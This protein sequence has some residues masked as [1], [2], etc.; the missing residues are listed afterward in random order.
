MKRV[1]TAK[2]IMGTNSTSS[3]DHANDEVTDCHD[4]PDDTR[5]GGHQQQEDLKHSL[6]RNSTPQDAL[7]AAPGVPASFAPTTGPSASSGIAVAALS[8]T[9]GQGVDPFS[10]ARSSL[11]GTFATAVGSMGMFDVAPNQANN[12]FG[13][14]FQDASDGSLFP[15]G[16]SGLS[17]LD[18][19]QMV[20]LLKVSPSGISER[21]LSSQAH[22]PQQLQRQHLDS[23]VPG[24]G[25]DFVQQQLAFGGRIRQQQSL[26]EMAKRTNNLAGNTGTAQ[27]A[28]ELNA[29]SAAQYQAA[30]ARSR[31]GEASSR[32]KDTSPNIEDL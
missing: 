14:L 29:F 7:S 3:A 16:A 26:E 13:Q 25:M 23:F 27:N 21:R 20:P 31:S 30:L 11:S 24:E 32:L 18:S 5:I 4:R 28:G 8:D 10:T 15:F 1:G 12:S 19:R 17:Q 2:K 22:A 6:I 9:R